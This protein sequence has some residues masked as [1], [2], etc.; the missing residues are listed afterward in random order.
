MLSF[1]MLQELYEPLWD[2]IYER[3]GSVSRRIRAIWIADVAQQGQ[4]GVLNETILGNDRMYSQYLYKDLPRIFVDVFRIKASW[5]DHGRDLLSLV[6]QYQ[7]EIPHPIIGIGHSMGGM[8]LYV[9]PLCLVYEEILIEDLQCPSF[10][11]A[12]C[13]FPGSYLD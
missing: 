13:P 7:D 9:W 2:D 12:P 8:Q 4:S 10:A 6:N 11:H 1:M 5:W 3:L